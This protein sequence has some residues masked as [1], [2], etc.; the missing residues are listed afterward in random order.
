MSYYFKN[1]AIYIG[2]K[3]R[4][5]SSKE[6]IPVM[7]AYFSCNGTEKDF[8]KC[9]VHRISRCDMKSNLHKPGLTCGGI[10]RLS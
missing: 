3:N 6:S 1:N 2:A 7:N 5:V 4:L 9:T 8:G 10:L